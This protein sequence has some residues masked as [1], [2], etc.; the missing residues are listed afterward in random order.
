MYQRVPFLVTLLLKDEGCFTK[1]AQ[2]GAVFDDVRNEVEQL[3]K[4]SA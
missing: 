3:I 1:N 4:L 2:M